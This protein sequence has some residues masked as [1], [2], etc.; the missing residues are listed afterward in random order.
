MQDALL[1]TLEGVDLG[2][3][4]RRCRLQRVGFGGPAG[5][6]TV[7]CFGRTAGVVAAA[8]AVPVRCCSQVVA[9]ARS[10]SVLPRVAIAAINF[11]ARDAA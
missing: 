7:F 2:N 10:A 8:D 5:V 11:R 4:Q 9:A 1:L 3:R 6:G